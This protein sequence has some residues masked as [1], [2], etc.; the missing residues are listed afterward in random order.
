MG[1]TRAHFIFFI[2]CMALSLCFQFWSLMASRFVQYHWLCVGCM[3]VP[4][5]QSSLVH[6]EGI[7]FWS[8]SGNHPQK[9]LEKWVMVLPQEDLAKSGYKPN[10]KYKSLIVL[11]YIWLHTLETKYK[12]S[13]DFLKIDPSPSLLAIEKLQKLFFYKKFNFNFFFP[14]HL[15]S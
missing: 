13:D 8:Q 7:F 4:L 6:F 14:P 15:G 2:M 10:V 3:L 12:G 5:Q 11:L 9:D 1:C